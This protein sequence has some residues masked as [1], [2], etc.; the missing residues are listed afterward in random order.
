MYLIS[1]QT[2]R[3]AEGLAKEKR[4]RRNNWIYIPWE[5][6]YCRREK[7]RDRRISDIKYLLGWFTDCEIKFLLGQPGGFLE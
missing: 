7:L 3:Q 6:G 1:A 4:L 5:P 2:I